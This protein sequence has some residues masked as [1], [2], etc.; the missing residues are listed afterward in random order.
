MNITF[1][2]IQKVSKEIQISKIQQ[3]IEITCHD[4]E[5]ENNLGN[6]LI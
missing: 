1:E 3:D 4:K 6:L 5:I 2:Y